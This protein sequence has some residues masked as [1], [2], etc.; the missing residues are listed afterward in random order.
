L[1]SSGVCS[2]APDEG[3]DAAD[4]RDRGVG[5]M[6]G[7]PHANASEIVLGV[8]EMRSLLVTVAFHLV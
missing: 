6:L 5:Q 4:D 8:G 3:R 2:G 7:R 1:P